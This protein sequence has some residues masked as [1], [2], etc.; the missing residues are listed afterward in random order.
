M[1][2]NRFATVEDAAWFD[3]TV[4]RVAEE[5]LSERLADYCTVSRYFVDFLR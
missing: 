5:E 3:K 1:V 2:K 4:K